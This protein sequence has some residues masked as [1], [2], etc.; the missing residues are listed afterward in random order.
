VAQREVEPNA[1]RGSVLSH[2]FADGVV[3]RRDV[4]G[5][6]GVTQAQ[7]VGE[8]SYAQQRRMRASGGQER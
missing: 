4:V 7:R 6:E 5:V 8:K 1:E 2:E 3:D